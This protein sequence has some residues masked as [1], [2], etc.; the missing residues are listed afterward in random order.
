M[1]RGKGHT[2]S[3]NETDEDIL[4]D[5]FT[6]IGDVTKDFKYVGIELSTQVEK[7]QEDQNITPD[8]MKRVLTRCLRIRQVSQTM[9]QRKRLL[10]MAVIPI[11]RWGGA[12][13]CYKAKCIKRLELL[14]E[15]TL[16]LQSHP[17]HGRSPWIIWHCVLDATLHPQFI[18]DYE[19]VCFQVRRLRKQ[20]LAARFGWAR[21]NFDKVCQRWQWEA[22]DITHIKTPLGVMDLT[23]VSQSV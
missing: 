22:L 6:D 18:Q 9:G 2:F 12:W 15:K 16:L 21:G 4:R 17:W 13:R 7:W 14:F 23:R 10:K 11:V 1:N 19:A 3:T 5:M 8:R 20:S